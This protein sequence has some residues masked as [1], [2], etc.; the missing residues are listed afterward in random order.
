MTIQ[1]M[2]GVPYIFDITTGK[3]VGRAT[4]CIL[5]PL[6]ES[7]DPNSIQCVDD[8]VRY[9]DSVTITIVQMLHIWNTMSIAQRQIGS[10]LNDRFN[11]Y[12]L[13]ESIEKVERGE[14]PDPH[15][16]GLTL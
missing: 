14:D 2:E 11:L 15:D 12:K 10:C 1:F 4:R 3:I 5:A 7:V 13:R 8:L 16:P 6:P 9:C